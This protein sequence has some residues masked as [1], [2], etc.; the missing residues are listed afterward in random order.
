MAHKIYLGLIDLGQSYH[1]YRIVSFACISS[2]IKK[3]NFN[4]RRLL[5][6]YIVGTAVIT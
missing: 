4:H 3:E 5:K 6:K 2:S 1:L